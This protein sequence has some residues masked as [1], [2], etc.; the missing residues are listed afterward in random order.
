MRPIK[1]Q[2]QTLAGRTGIEMCK[3]GRGKRWFTRGNKDQGGK[4]GKRSTCWIRAV[5][6]RARG[7][8]D[9]KG[10]KGGNEKCRSKLLKNKR[11]LLSKISKTLETVLGGGE[12]GGR[13]TLCCQ[14][15]NKG[16]I[17][18]GRGGSRE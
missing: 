9:N 1:G 11:G 2:K 12:Q 5:G 4:L 3:Q 8:R 14:K 13:M 10:R 6:G 17:S 15:K 16:N 7:G 18:N